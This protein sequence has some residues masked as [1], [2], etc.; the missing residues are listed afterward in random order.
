MLLKLFQS[1]PDFCVVHFFQNFVDFHISGINY[2]E[3]LP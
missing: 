3:I 1:P 2:F